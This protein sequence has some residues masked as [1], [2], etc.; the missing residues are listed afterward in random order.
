MEFYDEVIEI[1]KTPKTNRSN[2][3]EKG[4]SS[5]VKGESSAPIVPQSIDDSSRTTTKRPGSS[6]PRKSAQHAVHAASDTESSDSESEKNAENLAEGFNYKQ[7]E[8]LNVS[9]EIKDIYQYIA[10]LVD[11]LC[12]FFLCKSPTALTNSCFLDIHQRKSIL[13]I[14]CSHSYRILYQLLV[15]STHF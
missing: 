2:S 9:S 12:G 8:N 14:A 15:T 13:H 11:T 3:K 6:L 7:W 4:M 5:A 10:K 1:K